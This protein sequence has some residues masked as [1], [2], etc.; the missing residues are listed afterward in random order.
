MNLRKR[1]NHRVSLPDW[2][3]TARPFPLGPTVVEEAFLL[4]SLFIERDSRTLGFRGNGRIPIIGL[5]KA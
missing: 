3:W 2:G 4:T 1:A 5:L